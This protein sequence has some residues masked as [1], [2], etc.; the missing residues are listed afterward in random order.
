MY[1]WNWDMD[2][3]MTPTEFKLEIDAGQSALTRLTQAL[4]REATEHSDF[5]RFYDLPELWMLGSRINPP[6]SNQNRYVE[7][8]KRFYSRSDIID[9]IHHKQFQEVY[10]DL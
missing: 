7:E 3:L 2:I 9:R 6:I 1:V 8:L 5:P 10:A 4:G